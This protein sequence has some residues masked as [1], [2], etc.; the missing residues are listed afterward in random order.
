M[1]LLKLFF[2][3]AVCPLSPDVFELW[4]LRYFIWGMEFSTFLQVFVPLPYAFAS[5]SGWNLEPKA[6]VAPGL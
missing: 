3:F 4:L 5:Q 1:N 2:L 6:V